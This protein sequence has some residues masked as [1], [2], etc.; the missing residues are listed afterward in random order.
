[1]IS[2]ANFNKGVQVAN[3][4]KDECGIGLVMRSPNR[5][6]L[7]PIPQLK[8]QFSMIIFLSGILGGGDL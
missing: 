2:Y 3:A 8:F 7:L 5:V 4:T 1:M 6:L